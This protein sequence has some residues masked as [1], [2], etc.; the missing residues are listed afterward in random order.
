MVEQH[1]KQFKKVIA[2][3]KSLKIR[4]AK[5]V[6]VEA[7]KALRHI[8]VMAPQISRDGLLHN[9]EDARKELFKTRPTEPAMR[10]ALS[11]VLSGVN[12]PGTKED[13]IDHVD[14]MIASVLQYFEEAQQKIVEIGKHKIR[15]GSVVFTHCHSSTVTQI[16]IQAKKEGKRFEVHNTETRPSFQGRITAKELSDK[17]IPVM[18]FVDSAARYALKKADLFLIGAD[19]ITSEGKLINKVGSELFAEAARR[20]DVPVYV[21]THAW[22]FD[23]KTALGFEEEIEIRQAKEIWDNPP[24]NVKI[25]NYAFEQVDPSLVAGV[26]SELG[27]YKPQIFIQEVKKKYDWMFKN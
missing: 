27:I 22:K 17:G 21:C 2:D 18:H 11:F 23:P 20:F 19:A 5:N 9:L 1:M 6:A 12:D 16:L 8:L 4:G 14:K 25:Y 7:T 26:I 3:I 10:N 24:K 15:D 13:L